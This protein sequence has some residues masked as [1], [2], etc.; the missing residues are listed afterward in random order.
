MHV[1]LNIKIHAQIGKE[2]PNS[3]QKGRRIELAR[4]GDT[5][6][7]MDELKKELVPFLG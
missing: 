7:T 4:A 2:F 3:R 5:V 6:R 1:F